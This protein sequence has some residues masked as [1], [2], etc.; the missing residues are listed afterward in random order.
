MR[1][2]DLL[3]GEGLRIGTQARLTVLEISDDEVLVEITDHGVTR[4]EALSVAGATG[5]TEAPLRS[6]HR[7]R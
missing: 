4:V 6:E 1:V 2:L 5:D 7:T 3:E